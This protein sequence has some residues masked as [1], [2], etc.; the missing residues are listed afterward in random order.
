MSTLKK[1]VLQI[2]Q[3][4]HFHASIISLAYYSQFLLLFPVTVIIINPFITKTNIIHNTSKVSTIPGYPSSVSVAGFT[5]EPLKATALNLC[6]F[7]ERR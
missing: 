2:A 3:A 5:K 6:I 1:G 7:M 4:T